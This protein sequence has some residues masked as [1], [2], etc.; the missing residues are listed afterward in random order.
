MRG[1][2]RH[3]GGRCAA[4]YRTIPQVSPPTQPRGCVSSKSASGPH[5][6]MPLYDVIPVRVLPGPES[7]LQEFLVC[8]G[9]VSPA[10]QAK[11]PTKRKPQTSAVARKWSIVHLRRPR[12]RC[13]RCWI[14]CG[15]SLA[16][17]PRRPERPYEVVWAQ[18]RCRSHRVSVLL[19]RQLRPGP[20]HDRARR[21]VHLK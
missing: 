16:A 11:R 5:G 10:C 8:S 3:C 18:E 20:L 21:Q 9:G 2:R 12:S 13:C 17:L 4:F 7:S 19:G 14:S 6:V 15:T 1:K